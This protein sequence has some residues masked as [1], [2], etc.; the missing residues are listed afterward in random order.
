MKNLF[1]VTAFLMICLM[2]TACGQSVRT[3]PSP[4]APTPTTVTTSTL[5]VTPMLSVTP[6]TTLE[7]AEPPYKTPTLEPTSLPTIEPTLI[8]GLLNSGFEVEV[9]SEING[10][11][12]HRV[13]GWDYGF[14]PSYYCFGPYKW[15]NQNHLLLYPLVGQEY[16]MGMEQL[17]LPVVINY[18][19]GKVWIPS[20]DKISSLSNCYRPLWSDALNLL[21]TTRQK[22]VIVFNPEGEILN[23]YPG[24]YA[25]LSPSGTKLM[26]GDAWI[27]LLTGKTV[28][29]GLEDISGLSVWSSDEMQLFN[30]CYAYGNA[31]TGKA[32]TFDL[33]GLSY[34]GRDYGAGFSGITSTWVMNDT[35]VV[36]Y[37]DFQNATEYDIFPLIE[38]ATQT[39]KDIQDLTDIPDDL[40]C[41]LGSVAP[42]R[43]Q[44]WVNCF[45][46][47]NYLVNLETFAA[48]PYSG[49]LNLVAWSADSK[50]AWLGTFINDDSPQILSVLDKKLQLLPISAQIETI[51]W[52]PNDAVL[53]YLSTEKQTLVLLNASTMTVQEFPLPSTFRNIVWGPNGENI[54]LVNEDGSL[55]Q[56][57]YP[58]LENLEQLTSPLPDVHDVMW[59]PDGDYIAFVSGSDIYIVETIK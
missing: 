53:A 22:E 23:R 40:S 16:G 12:I 43:K 58:K 9:Y 48:Q 5:A 1:R 46:P 50:F 29:F 42:D 18:E 24:Y 49:D 32:H 51:F 34:V 26:V 56:V 14:R 30:C 28:D 39:Y 6:T 2:F 3:S 17:S 11:A 57:D 35:Y 55:W 54:A 44:I 45:K 31:R 36:T 13:T 8:P 52:H 7:Y 27:D 37:W 4:V 38:P 25:S 10:H 59:S 41:G 15:M 20:P 19:S 47:S 21:I 33:G